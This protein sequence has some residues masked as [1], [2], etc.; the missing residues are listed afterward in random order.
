MV[1]L[2]LTRA[3][4]NNLSG[5]VEL[6][7]V[8]DGKNFAV[9]PFH[10][11]QADFNILMPQMTQT[12]MILRVFS[13]DCE[14]RICRGNA[15]VHLDKIQHEF[16]ELRVHLLSVVDYEIMG[17]VVFAVEHAPMPT[18]SPAPT[19][20]P[21]PAPVIVPRGASDG[22]IRGMQEAERD[23][24]LEERDYQLCI[25]VTLRD[26][27]H[28]S[29][30]KSSSDRRRR[31]VDRSIGQ[32]CPRYI[33]H[34]EYL[35][36]RGFRPSYQDYPRRGAVRYPARHSE[37]FYPSRRS[38]VF[39]PSMPDARPR[40]VVYYEDY[41]PAGNPTTDLQRPAREARSV[42][43]S[44]RRDAR[45]PDAFDAAARDA[46]GDDGYSQEAPVYSDSEDVPP[47]RR[48]AHDLGEK[49]RRAV[50][51]VARNVKK[52]EPI[53]IDIR[54]GNVSVMSSIPV[55]T[56]P[57]LAREKRPNLILPI[58]ARTD[59]INP[60]IDVAAEFIPPRTRCLYASA[61]TTR[62]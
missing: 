31:F 3:I 18:P 17:V 37:V 9:G 33:D 25:P 40:R 53:Q 47:Q 48:P 2:T 49:E 60:V 44:R 56:T 20:I 36:D 42:P 15:T 21:A 55:P 26:S 6:E 5:A 11:P 12:P 39:Y 59:P 30:A 16:E 61:P 62:R 34:G 35:D 38:E 28:K 23:A 8:V 14:G 46:P 41:K 29:L 54:V 45:Q 27:P 51:E 52:A 4:F 57:R 32:E 10:A 43:R 24:P 13:V 58:N 7:A 1:R 19:P 22:P 50:K